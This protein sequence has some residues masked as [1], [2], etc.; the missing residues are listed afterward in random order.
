DDVDAFKRNT[1]EQLAGRARERVLAALYT[2]ELGAVI[3]IRARDRSKVMQTL[4][5]AGLGACTHVIGQLNNRDEIRFTRNN[6]PVYANK[7]DHMQRIWGELT[8]RMQALR[9]HP[10]AAREEY[11]RI[12]DL[13]DSGLAM[14]L[15]FEIRPAAINTGTRPRVAI[16]REQGVN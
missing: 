15:R 3:Q 5:E 7:R 6:K 2:E 9:D 14:D 10:E 8:Y 4:R 16:L 12:I 13:N 1:E 11:D